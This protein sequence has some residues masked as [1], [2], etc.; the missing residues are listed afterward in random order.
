MRF[1]VGQPIIFLTKKHDGKVFGSQNSVSSAVHANIERPLLKMLERRIRRAS[2]KRV[3]DLFEILHDLRWRPDDD[4][5]S[6]A[7]AHD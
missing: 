7:S 6:G 2:H 5:P 4:L 3:S 1:Y